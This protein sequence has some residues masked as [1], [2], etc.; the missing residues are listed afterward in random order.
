[1]NPLHVAGGTPALPAAVKRVPGPARQSR[2]DRGLSSASDSQ[3]WIT[4]L[5]A[6]L[7]LWGS[8]GMSFGQGYF[9][10]TGSKSTVW[11]GFTDPNLAQRTT[12]VNVAFLWA[13]CGTP[14]VDSLMASVPNSA[15]VNSSA[16]L[17]SQAWQLILNDPAFTLALNQNAGNAVVVAQSLSTGA[18]AYSSG[19]MHKS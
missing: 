19:Q 14:Q 5:A 13:T 2:M 4:N 3:K 1:M 17:C 8:L 7:V 6:V 15:T 16:Y 10:F 9:Q 18:F 12:H 11:D